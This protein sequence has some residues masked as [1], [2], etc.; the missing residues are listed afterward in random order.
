MLKYPF[1]QQ[2]DEKDCGAAC[3]SMISEF[4]GLKL[5]I[6]RCR[7]LIKVDN[8]GAN[9]Y[10][11]VTGAEKI[12]LEAEALE[13]TLEE[14][15]EGIS[16]NEIIFPFIARIIN[17]QM[18]EHFVVVYAMKRNTFVIGDPAKNKLIYV[19]VSQFEKQ[20]QGQIITFSTKE[21]FVRMNKR[22]DEFRKFFRFIFSQK[23][24]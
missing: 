10:G 4:Y 17:E 2:H 8:H 15:I 21:S 19:P 13:G 6:A 24:C 12:G 20:W 5:P 14:L 7:E 11:L 3:L 18:F 16:N 23:N 9:I 22:K 1:I